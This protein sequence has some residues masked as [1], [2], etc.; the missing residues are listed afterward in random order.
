M[1]EIL[2]S[3]GALIGRPNGRDYK[4]LDDFSKQLSC[5]GFEFM[6]YSTWYPEE[7]E[8]LRFMS[9]KGFNIPVVHCEKSIGE[10][11]SIGGKDDL[12]VAF[13]RFEANCRMA[14]ELGAKKMVV[15][16]WGGLA[17]DS[18]FQSN[19]D[20]YPLLA[21]MCENH[22][23][24]LLIENVV[25]NHQ[26]PLTHWCRLYEK[27]PDIHF[28]FDTKMAEF[29]AQTHKLYGGECEW[30]WKEEHLRHFHVNDYAGEYMEWAKLR[31]LPI[32]G[33]HVDFGRFF[34][35]IHKIGYS[36]SFTVE[37]TAFDADG[38]VDF[39]MLNRQ[40]DYIRKAVY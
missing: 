16:L 30:L 31:T 29:H 12:A 13:S 15:H 37:S 26:D 34:D 25:C 3:T 2:C 23:I 19:I 22:G 17:S 35:F 6:I 28:V 36:D 8:L 20:A 40:F 21:E 4:L 24:D 7:A 18:N 32:G 27:Y 38:K 9:A 1:A 33:G 11:I 10:S 39:Q 14:Q 5:D